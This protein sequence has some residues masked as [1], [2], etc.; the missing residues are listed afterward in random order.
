MGGLREVVQLKI[1]GRLEKASNAVTGF[2]DYEGH[3]DLLR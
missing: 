1:L 2:Y 3:S